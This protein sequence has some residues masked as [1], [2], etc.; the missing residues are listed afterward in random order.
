MYSSCVQQNNTNNVSDRFL[1]YWSFVWLFYDSVIF[2]QQWGVKW[3]WKAA[4]TLLPLPNIPGVLLLWIHIKGTNFFVFKDFFLVL[5]PSVT[6]RRLKERRNKPSWN[7]LSIEGRSHCSE[8]RTMLL[9]PYGYWVM[10][11]TGQALDLR[12]QACQTV[13]LEES[14]SGGFDLFFLIQWN[15]IL[16]R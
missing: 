8:T 16:K 10:R 11:D 12:S 7:P 1:L 15:P 6:G 4:T 2:L 14:D 5:V 13:I 3:Y 9:W